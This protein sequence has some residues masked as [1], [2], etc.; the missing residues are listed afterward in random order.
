MESNTTFSG[1]LY[2]Y[3]TKEDEKGETGKNQGLEPLNIFLNGRTMVVEWNDKTKTQSTVSNTD[4][5]SLD[6]GFSICL[7]KK[8]YGK[9]IYGKPLYMRMIKSKLKVQDVDEEVKEHVRDWLVEYG[10][11]GKD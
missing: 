7:L 4:I 6:I 9:K 2:L 5:P 11:Y 3:L 1:S 10:E 8:M